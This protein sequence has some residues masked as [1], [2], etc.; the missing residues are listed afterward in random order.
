[1]RIEGPEAYGPVETR[2]LL[3]RVAANGAARPNELSRDAARATLAG[4]RGRLGLFARADLDR[5]M[6]ANALDPSSMERLVEDEAR[7]EALCERFRRSIGSALL[8]ELRLNG[9]YARLAERALRKEKA[10]AAAGLPQSAGAPSA[11][12]S[13]AARL[14]YFEKRL[15]RPTPDDIADFARRV[16]FETLAAFD[17]AVHR[18]WAFMNAATPNST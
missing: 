17:A 11:L 15:G 3:R 5:W 2:A 7:L 1:M 16:G 4:M 13:T 18:E 14:W 8:D 9:A 10:L 6:S 12:R